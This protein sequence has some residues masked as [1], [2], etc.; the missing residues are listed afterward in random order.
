M[1]EFDDIA[2]QL[3]AERPELT[4]LELDQV[5]QRVRK[6]AQTERKGQSMRSRLAM[7]LMLAL[8][9]MISTTGAGLAIQGATGNGNAAQ[10]QYPD[11][12]PDGG[13]LGEEDQEEA[14]DEDTGVAGEEDT[15][16]PQVERQ[17]EVGVQGAGSELPFTG[18]AA[19]PI[20]LLGVA[21]TIGGVAIR[22]KAGRA[23][24]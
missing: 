7:V 16:T 3:R 9:I 4:E 20:L 24:D 22:R 17:V 18:F 5:K 10:E 1:N 2:R 11:D 8:G 6:R 12:T 15:S 21:L 13:V 14:P 19:I 23:D